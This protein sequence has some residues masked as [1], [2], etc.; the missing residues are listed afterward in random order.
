MTTVKHEQTQNLIPVSEDPMKI[1]NSKILHA[2][3]GLLAFSTTATT[4]NA[5]IQDYKSKKMGKRTKSQECK[6][7]KRYK[8]EPVLSDIIEVDEN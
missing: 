4:T 8:K 2:V 7:Y 1:T 5:K 3:L 6:Q